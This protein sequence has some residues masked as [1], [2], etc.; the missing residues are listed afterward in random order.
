MLFCEA[1]GLRRRAG[2]RPGSWSGQSGGECLG[3]G[4]DLF[5]RALRARWR[6][7]L[8]VLNADHGAADLVVVNKADGDLASVAAHLRRY[9]A[10]LTRA[11][12]LPGWSAAGADLLSLTAPGSPRSGRPSPSSR[13]PATE[14]APADSGGSNRSDVVRKVTASLLDALT[15]LRTADLPAPRSEV[16]AGP[17]LPP[18]AARRVLDAQP[19]VP[20]PP[21]SVL[22]DLHRHPNSVGRP[23]YD[24]NVMKGHP[25]VGCSWLFVRPGDP[26]RRCVVGAG[27]PT[28]RPGL[29]PS[30]NATRPGSESGPRT[31]R[32]NGGPTSFRSSIPHGRLAHHRSPADPPARHRP[33]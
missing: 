11:A 7:E 1:A 4:C 15:P 8:Q 6:D 23:E 17:P 5:P 9:A 13:P 29:R 19:G 12:P 2:S 31:R 18:A 16:A 21:D 26:C 20:S 3:D 32:K 10:A 25:R 28:S 30:S 22:E 27:T 24:E 14:I 33:R